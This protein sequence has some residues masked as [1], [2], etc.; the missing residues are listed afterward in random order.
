MYRVATKRTLGAPMNGDVDKG[1]RALKD[2]LRSQPVPNSFP[3]LVTYE[4][5]DKF[6]NGAGATIRIPNND[7]RY[8]DLLIAVHRECAG[9]GTYTWPA[10]WNEI[11]DST[12]DGSVDTATIAYRS[13]NFDSNES[14]LV[15]PSYSA[16]NSTGVSLCWQ[17]RG[18]GTPSISSVV[19]ANTASPNPPNLA[20][21][22]GSLN[23]LWIALTTCEG[24]RRPTTPPTNYTLNSGEQGGGTG[25]ANAFATLSWGMR[26]LNASSQDP[27]T[28]TLTGAEDTMTWTLALPPL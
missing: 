14:Y 27:G 2:V 16:T 13:V 22:L 17:F 7:L 26:E 11:A 6:I 5:T 18:A 20:P 9:A 3:Y 1:Q 28:F 10:G 21:G 19:A 23:F 8:G 4:G 25:A 24:D 15:S 12:A